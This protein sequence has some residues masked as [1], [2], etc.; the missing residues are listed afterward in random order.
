[1]K[2]A[3]D[4]RS[5]LAYCMYYLCRME[6]S[7]S[8]IDELYKSTISKLPKEDRLSYCNQRLDKAQLILEKNKDILDDQQKTALKE[9]IKA[10]QDEIKRINQSSS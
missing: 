9:L 3:A 5:Y 10:A 7:F 1:M 6:R 4:Q 2:N 8:N